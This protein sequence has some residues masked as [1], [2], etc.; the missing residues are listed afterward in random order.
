[1]LLDGLGFS[2]YRSFGNELAK[3]APL[4]KVKL[5]IGQNNIG[6]SNIINFLNEQYSFFVT[7]ATGNAPSEQSNGFFPF[8][9]I[10]S[11]NN[12]SVTATFIL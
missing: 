2:G 11:V 5:I 3:I 8:L 6:K 9:E 10:G 7:K 12:P 4:K 1:M